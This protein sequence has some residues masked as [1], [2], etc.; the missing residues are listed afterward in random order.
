MKNSMAAMYAS[1]AWITCLH[2]VGMPL[3][4]YCRENVE[5]G[6]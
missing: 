1:S 5:Q 4:S 6:N 2:Q 3:E